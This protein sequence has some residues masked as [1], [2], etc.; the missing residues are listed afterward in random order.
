MTLSPV[1]TLLPV[2]GRPVTHPPSS[3]TLLCPFSAAGG[4]TVD[5]WRKLPES[6]ERIELIDGNFR[7]SPPPMGLHAL[8]A[9]SLRSILARAVKP[10]LVAVE[11]VNVVVGED[12]LIP[13]V[14]VLPRDLVMSRMAVFPAS[15]VVAVAEVVSPGPGNR[16]RDHE[17][18]PLRY[19]E[20]KP[21]RYAE[22]G[23]ELFIRIDLEGSGIP[24]A[25]VLT[26]GAQGYEPAG[27]AKAGESLTLPEPF[28]ASFGP[29][30][31]LL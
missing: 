3:H 2:E 27:H 26:L 10:D 4:H 8:C 14:A 18:R 5:D 1:M 12:G 20:I 31:L 11:T 13:D 9:G 16:G 17:I 30:D 21:L 15:E 28:P 24:R 6:R 23:I 7:V 29:A 19:Y 25:E 22:A